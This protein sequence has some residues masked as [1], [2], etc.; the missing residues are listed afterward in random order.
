[1]RLSPRILVLAG[2]LATGVASGPAFA[3]D[4]LN[5]NV[6]PDR[7]VPSACFSF[8]AE[9]PRGK[10][11]SLE[12]FVAITPAT[13]HSLEARGKDL[14]VGGLKHGNHYAFRLKAGLPGADGTVLAKDVPVAVDIPDREA[15]VS[16]DQGKTLL[17]YTKG[18]GLP[19]KSIN[20]A[21]AHVT[22][23]R[24]SDRTMVDHL[25]N[26]WFGQ[27]VSGY[28]L[29]TIEDRAQKLF[30]GSVDIAQVRNQEISTTLPLD[31]LVKTLEPGVY[32]A[33]ATTP[34][35]RLDREKERA[36]VWFSVSDIGLVT[37]K[38]DSGLLVAAHSLQS[39]KP[40]A[41]VELRLVSR[42]NEVLGSYRTDGEGRVTIP[43]A[44]L[45][46]EH[47]DAPKILS[48]LD[49]SGQFS[50]I[51][52][53]QPALDLSDLDIKGRA[54]PTTN[55]AFL[56]TDRGVYRPGETIHLGTLLRDRNGQPVTGVPL[57]LHI[58]RPD[59]VEVEAR[60]LPLAQAG[61][62]TMDI[63]TADNAISGTWRLWAGTAD[64]T[65]VGETSVSVQDFVPPRLE[66]KVSAPQG[67]VAADGTITAD[68]AADY[69]YGSPGAGLTGSVE[70]TLQAAETP[71]K[72]LDGFSFGLT[73]E[74]FLAKSLPAQDFTT[75]DKGKAQVEL[76]PE[77]VPDTTVPLEVALRATVNDVDGRSVVAETTKVLHTSDR[78]I[79]IR[80]TSENLADGSTATFEIALVDGDGK[81]L[82]PESLKWDL[83]REDYDYNFFYR[84]GR[85]QSHETITDARVNGGDLGLDARGRGTISAKVTNGRWR[86][87]AY[88]AAGKTAT[89][90]RFAAGWWASSE[91]QS[92]KPE[93]MNV[94]VDATPPAGKVRA[95]VEP[96]FAGRV[97][98]ML[99]GNGLHGVQEVDMRK[100]GGAVEFD[101]ADVPAS[102]AYVVAVAIS[103][104]GAVVPRLPVRAVG[105]A[106]VA[107]AAAGHK[108]DVAIA[109]PEKV[110]PQSALDVDVAVKGEA[111]GDEA[112][113]T[114][115]AVDEAVLRMTDFA[116]PDAA[117]H[118]NGRRAL[119]VELRDVYNQL[120][121][122]AG[123][124]GRLTQG[125]DGNANLKMGGLDVKTFKTVAFFK[126]PVKLDADGHAKITLAVPDFSG[127]LRL[128]AQ[129]WT[130][131]RFGAADKP[132]TVRPALLAE[133]TLPR[134]L[135]PGDKIRARI[136][137]TDLEAA[138]QT[139]HVAMKATGAI[140]LD[141]DDALFED[142]KR[143]RRRFVD[144][145]IVAGAT[146]GVGRIHMAVTGD[147]GTSVAR[148]FEI[149][150]R[151]PNAFTTERRIVTLAPGQKLAIDDTLGADLVPG[152]AKLDITAS[153]GP[154]I[155]V[156]GLLADLRQYP[157]GCAEQTISRAFPELFA[158]RLGARLP[159]Q[160]AEAVS[161]QGAIQRL[162]SL[163]SSDGSFGYWTSFDTG[164]FWLTAYAVDF[165]Q[166]ARAA[167]VNVPQDMEARATSWLAGQFATVGFEP[168][169]TAGAAYA[170][171]VLSRADKLDLSQLRYVA[172]RIRGKLPSDLAR[173]QMAA[174]LSHVGERDMA[175]DFLQSAVV[176]RNPAV[177]LNDYGSQIRDQAMSLSL[178]AEEKLEPQTKLITRADDLAR[179]SAK[180]TWLSTQ[181]EAWLL[182]AAFDLTAPTP[183]AV[184]MNGRPTP[185][186]ART[187]HSV[188]P[189][190]RG[191][192]TDLANDGASPISV[193]L[194]ATG[195]PAGAQPAES[196]GFSVTRSYYDLDGTP[197]NLADVHQNDELVVTVEGAMDQKFQRKILAVDMLPAG[198]EPET[199][200]LSTDRDDGQ[201][202]W[203]K[204][205]T[206]PTFFAL[207]DDRYLA[208]MDLYEGQP[209]FKFAYVV[210][211]VTPGTFA[212]PGPHVE[213]MYAPAFHARGAAGTLVVLPARS[214]AAAKP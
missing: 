125:G 26:D 164:N 39:A 4:Y 195:I 137:V 115:A 87:E 63:K 165:M 9:L 50:W 156:P 46:G 157:Y 202:A 88:D 23:Y 158:K 78:F 104:A 200:G 15:Q 184:T 201:F 174:A 37:V 106:W 122:P 153:T 16:F 193:A 79:G 90:V 179:V 191:L 105:I 175:T 186:G 207:R 28:G 167:G 65:Q 149:S 76:K 210:R 8:T 83:V 119:D 117:D 120:I 101:A 41:G 183:L 126:G 144:R 192:K 132:V 67:P 60:P 148:D 211:A 82:P 169:D 19:L 159:T 116:T 118:F 1:M 100:G 70:A 45:R 168:R 94:T 139:W 89:S 147:D 95:M 127:G 161:G 20:V 145:T 108:L 18:V 86:L 31:Q 163:Q 34:S 128:M 85:W 84:D 72:D 81:A 181:E 6:Q 51:E 182:R 121:D 29:E 54:P 93:V 57:T 196:A 189:L 136:L 206:E 61:G 213:D 199:V 146:P 178:A 176:V 112:Y 172:T 214:P 25:A 203:L 109:A 204:G 142:V 55:D 32:V 212:N 134:F 194:A 62:G 102:G 52:L 162:Y 53:D 177:Y 59:G 208:G 22:L 123:Q 7:A 150:V 30:D 66:A 14:C 71:F 185:A 98:V 3:L 154:A 187:V 103:P 42:A 2:L 180:T 92:R 188:M 73:Q 11:Q 140:A 170:A 12:P 166:H 138:E 197:A 99:D 75:D 133:L 97:L 130:G 173:L 5:V 129:A 35:D 27:G 48:A 151:S 135:A 152:T 33:L 198:L 21:K 43:G 17:P 190:A 47:G 141:R 113:V 96:S 209:R 13:D 91:Q 49:G 56:W 69:F 107:G 68:V 171:I 111:P 10:A 58:V 124:P 110:R 40:M 44:L 80:Q 160:T 155:D 38:T 143:D 64:K 24:F 131:T 205:L 77:Q 74:P 36:T 114:L